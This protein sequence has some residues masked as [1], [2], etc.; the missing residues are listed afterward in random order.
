MNGSNSLMLYLSALNSSRNGSYLDLLNNVRFKQKLMG[1]Y[2]MTVLPFESVSSKGCDSQPAK[3]PPEPSV[4]TQKT[5]PSYCGLQMTG[6]DDKMTLSVMNA[7]W[8]AGV[9]LS[10][11]EID[12]RA[13]LYAPLRAFHPFLGISICRFLIRSMRGVVIQA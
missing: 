8:W 9:H 7:F 4:V 5:Y 13:C 6:S 1:Y 11:S 2:L 12:C 3:P 10:F